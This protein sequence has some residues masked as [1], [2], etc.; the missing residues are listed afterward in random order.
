[1]DGVLIDGYPDLTYELQHPELDPSEALTG[2][3][4]RWS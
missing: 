3:T 4:V 1:M 2:N